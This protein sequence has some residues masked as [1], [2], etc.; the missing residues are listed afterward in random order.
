MTLTTNIVLYNN[1]FECDKKGF[2]TPQ[3]PRKHL[4]ITHEIH[5]AA[6]PHGIRRR[7]T[8]EFNFVKEDFA[9]PKVAHSACPSCLQHF[10]KIN[11]LKSHFDTTHLL[12]HPSD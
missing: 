6:T 7:N 9:P 11:D 2:T 12:D 3:K 1:C 4:R 8:D 10:E 5:V